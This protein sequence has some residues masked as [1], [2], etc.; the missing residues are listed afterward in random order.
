MVRRLLLWFV[1][2]CPCIPAAGQSVPGPSLSF[3]EK[4]VVASGLTAGAKVIWFSVEG[5]I[6]EAFSRD[7]VQRFRVADAAADGTVRLELE[8]TPSARSYWVAVDLPSGAFALSAP[9][10]TPI[11]TPGKPSQLLRAV[12]GTGT[13]EI[14]DDRPYVIGLVVRPGTGAW[15]FAGG[16]GGDL[17]ADGASDGLAHFGLDLFEPLPGSPAAP[18]QVESTD[19]WFVVDPLKMEISVHKGGVAQ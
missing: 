11:L 1:I 16:D 18:A 2:V 15:T 4:A 9:E 19:L 13:D 3:E 14:V 10:G 6:D 7:L 12:G 8:D 5:R 17:D